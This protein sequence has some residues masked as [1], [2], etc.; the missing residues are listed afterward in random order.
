MTRKDDLQFLHDAAITQY[1]LQDGM[2]KRAEFS[3]DGLKGAITSYFAGHWDPND[4]TGSFLNAIVPGAISVLIGGW[5]GPLIGFG[6]KFLNVDL[7][8]VLEDI[9]SSLK[10][11]LSGSNKTL[12]P[13]QIDQTVQDAIQKNPKEEKP[14][15]KVPEKLDP[16]NMFAS[17]TS[18]SFEQD[19]NNAK[20]LKLAMT[21]HLDGSIK[22]KDL[23]KV[24]AASG[25]SALL[26]KAISFIF[27][28]L[29]MSAGL[30]VAGDVANKV[31]NRPN[32]FDSSEN[33]RGIPQDTSGPKSTVET[34]SSQKVF[35]I[36]TTYDHQKF[37]QSEPW[38]EKVS[39]TQTGIENLLI[40]FA[41]EVYHGLDGLEEESKTLPKFQA[42]V[43]SLLWFNRMT[44]GDPMVFIPKTFTTKEGISS[45]WID[46]LAS[47]HPNQ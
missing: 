47:K 30:M 18:S 40:S 14:E 20:I 28:V 25:K 29:A 44:P 41:K 8:G 4:K 23:K 17:F 39:N 6:L 21:S 34:I 10:A 9:Y 32:A 24:L 22:D 31:L 5:L 16:G 26:V 7:G 38:V 27:K 37:N 33:K 1:L 15:F 35:P 19:W 13:Q 12:S 36:S 45:Y 2:E 3:I 43:Q 46:Q 11:H 42:L